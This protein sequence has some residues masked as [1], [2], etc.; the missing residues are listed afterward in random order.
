MTPADKPAS[1]PQSPIPSR[2]A[3]D[4]TAG[5]QAGASS[6][7]AAATHGGDKADAPKKVHTPPE[8]MPERRGS[9]SDRRQRAAERDDSG[10]VRSDA[11]TGPD[12]RTGLDRRAYLER[13][14]QM[15][16]A[17][18]MRFI[19][20]TALTFAVFFFL[21]VLAGVFLLAPEYAWLKKRAEQM[22]PTEVLTKQ[23]VP[24]EE[25]VPLGLA[26]NRQLARVENAKT[27]ISDATQA[28]IDRAGAAGAVAAET[29]QQL[30]SGDQTGLR[31]LVDFIGNTRMMSSSSQGQVMLDG[32]VNELKKN[33]AGWQGDAATFDAAVAK[34][35]AQDPVLNEMLGSVSAQDV[36]A[37][38]ML[39]MMGEF[40]G[41]LDSG[42]PFDQDLAVV[43]RL[44]GSDPQL[45][46]SLAQ[47][48]PYAKS[49]VL[50]RETLQKEFKGLAMDIV[51]AKA[52]GQNANVQQRAQARL[53]ELVKVRK[54]DDMDG[55]GTDAVVN[56]AQALLDKG[57]INGA[58]R[59]LQALQ[60]AP[61]DAAAP[62]IA[63]A[64]GAL[65][66]EQSSDMLMN[67]VLGQLAAGGGVSLEG[68]KGLV[69]N[70]LGIDQPVNPVTGR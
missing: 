40:R 42:R 14:R 4:V 47:L 65:A 29:A 35:R 22:A 52:T 38:A 48:A 55:A 53:N 67:A 49:G 36:G 56:R 50:T 41:N 16:V 26:L 28:M 51:T 1:D 60:G 33:L 69:T 39:L 68:L 30:A 64:Q 34:S 9:G 70:S 6:R 31:A 58:V 3:S 2:R 66:A 59:E 20:R 10:Y 63:Q 54:V 62:F 15:I 7:F 24:E 44:A 11:Y 12:R 23:E 5:E 57:D 25:S 21:I 37:A 61:A 19:N 32:A 13:Q 17:E 8:G 18:K 27:E 46:K 43:S 45:Q